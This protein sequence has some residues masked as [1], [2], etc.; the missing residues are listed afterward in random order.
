MNAKPL[1]CR[2]AENRRLTPEP[3]GARHDVRHVTLRY[4]DPF[5]YLPG[6]SVGILVP[7]ADEAGRPHKVRLYSIA[8]VAAGDAGDG[9][10]VSLCAIR[11]FW[12]D[13]KTGRKGI[14]GVASN[15]LC[16]AKPGDAVRITG[17]F[18]K[19]FLLPEDT[20]GR[21]FIFVAT[22]TGIAPFRGMLAE[23]YASGFR[24]RAWLYF[25]VPYADMALYD[26]E[27]AAYGSRPGF[28][29]VKAVSREE[30]NPVPDAVPTREGRMYVQVRMHLDRERLVPALAN[31]K[32]VVYLCGL[33]GME[34]GIFPV[35]DRLGE[36]L[37]GPGPFTAFLKGQD[38]LKVEVY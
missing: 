17:P 34:Q 8:S 19:H 15:Y 16:D 10:T 25:G 22:G 6:Q 23:L 24:G 12:D 29:Y 32:S 2:V 11:H 20:A 9:K 26:G 3:R 38:R 13:P 1:A 35:L 36:G 21:D 5:A 28:S 30:K 31:P 7:G 33:K 27:F 4:E 37:G 18:G 14:P